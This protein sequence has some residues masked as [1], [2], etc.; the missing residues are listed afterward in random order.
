M[1]IHQKGSIHSWPI[2]EYTREHIKMY[3]H[4]YI[5]H[6]HILRE[7]NSTLYSFVGEKAIEEMHIPRGED[8]LFLRKPC[9]VCLT[10]CLFSHYFM[11]LSVTFSIYA[12]L[13]SLH[14]VYVLDMHT[15]LRYCALLVAY[16]D[17]HLLYYMIIVVISIWLSCVWSSCS[18]VSQHVYLIAFYLLH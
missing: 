7:R 17:D 11:V 14:R 4:F 15:S 6:V 12:L 5:T 1:L 3:R 18:Y 16:S 8:I 10:L 9:F 2:R 13:L